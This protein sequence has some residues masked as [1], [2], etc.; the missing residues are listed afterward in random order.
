[1]EA[2]GTPAPPANP[3]AEPPPPPTPTA[4]ADDE[5]SSGPVRFLAV[6]LALALAFGSAVMIVLPL[7]PDNTPRCEQVTLGECFDLTKTQQLIQNLLAWPAGILGAIAVVLCLYLAATGRRA[8]LVRKFAIP[9]VILGIL[10]V[11]VGQL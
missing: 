11:I 1:M 8:D 5:K 4:R 10:A 3:P 7:N 2:S 6:I 9:A